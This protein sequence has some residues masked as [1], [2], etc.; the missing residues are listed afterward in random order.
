MKRKLTSLGL[1]F[2]LVISF[3]AFAPQIATDDQYRVEVD[4]V[5]GNNPIYYGEARPGTSIATDRWRIRKLTWTGD[6]FDGASWA[7]QTAAF[8]KVWTARATYTYY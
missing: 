8:D 7:D 3:L 2:L 4:N 1:A 5:G 6:E